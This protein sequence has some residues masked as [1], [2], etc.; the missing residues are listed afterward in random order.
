M[1][2]LLV[3]AGL[4]GTATAQSNVAGA[5]LSIVRSFLEA[6]HCPDTTPLENGPLEGPGAGQVV[7]C[8][9]DFSDGSCSLVIQRSDGSQLNDG[10]SYAPGEVL[11]FAII[12]ACQLSADNACGDGREV[13]M[14]VEGA[15][16]EGGEGTRGCGNA[17]MI[18]PFRPPEVV[19]PDDGPVTFRGATAYCRGTA[20]DGT[21]EQVTSQC[22]DNFHLADE[23]T[24][25]PGGSGPA[26]CSIC[27]G[28]IDLAVVQGDGVFGPPDRNYFVV[29]VSDLL[30][31][32]PPPLSRPTLTT[33]GRL[34]GADWSSVS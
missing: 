13:L 7:A 28:D 9:D 33:G 1:M 5:P 23:I 27:T 24:L 10:D 19:M 29:D 26:S 32:P 8:H 16:F 4:L 22:F 3:A 17:R 20:N 34:L 30:Y 12:S 2:R 18:N 21:D 6:N 11:T 15:S 14:E 25:T 31:A